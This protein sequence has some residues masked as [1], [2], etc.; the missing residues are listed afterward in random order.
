MTPSAVTR[1]P[2]LRVGV[3]AAGGRVIRRGSD[4]A[5]RLVVVH[6][7]RYDDW[8]FPKGKQ[9]RG[10]TLLAAALREVREETGFLCVAESS[11]GVTEYIDRGERPKLVR[12]WVMDR[13]NG[14]FASN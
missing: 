8:S 12:Y 1:D 11:V 2:Q 10:E 13:V 3:R 6:R 9:R 4:D 14:V 7:P 5:V